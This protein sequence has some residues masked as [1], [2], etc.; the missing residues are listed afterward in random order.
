MGFLE[1]LRAR[2][3]GDTESTHPSASASTSTAN[4]LVPLPAD[5]YQKVVG[6]SH[7]QPALAATAKIC[8]PGEDERPMFTAYLLAEPE[9][10]YDADA[11]AVHSDE[12][13]LGYLS[14]EDAQSFRA[15]FAELRARGNG[16]AT[17]GAFLTGGDRNPPNY[18][19]VLRLSRPKD[20]EQHLGR[21]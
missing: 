14:R 1:T 13:K 19:V 4:S 6:E 9:N 10:P 7:Y 2:L 11:I 8:R 12:G 5:S 3:V 20:C 21:I 18:G 16:G 15:T 17:C